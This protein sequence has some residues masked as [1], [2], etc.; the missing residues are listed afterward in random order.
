M[1][2]NPLREIAEQVARRYTGRATPAVTRRDAHAG[3]PV[4]AAGCP[5][6]APAGPR[7]FV[8][9]VDTFDDPTRVF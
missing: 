2:M 6:N 1:R 4:P 8:A 9:A 7:C 3:A 5:L